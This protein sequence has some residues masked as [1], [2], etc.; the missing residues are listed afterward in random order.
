[1]KR[2]NSAENKNAIE[3]FRA[4]MRGGFRKGEIFVICSK[5][6]SGKSKFDVAMKGI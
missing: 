2:G 1:M 4:K 5:T 3:D 6:S